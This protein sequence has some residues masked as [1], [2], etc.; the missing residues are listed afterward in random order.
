M[1]N[2]SLQ[3]N[4]TPLLGK[5]AL[6]IGASGGIGVS[7]AIML[8]QAG[9]TLELASRN[10]HKLEL[11]AEKLKSQDIASSTTECDISEPDSI[12]SLKENIEARGNV[13]ILV[14]CAGEADI[15]PLSFTDFDLWNR[16]FSIN[17]GGSF[18]STQAFIS[19]M[20]KGGWGRI[21][22]LGSQAGMSGAP[23]LSAYAASKQAVVGFV[24]SV[25]C[26]VEGKG[27][28]INA[29]CPGPVD[30]PMMQ[31]LIAK[32]ARQTASSEDSI[33]EIYMSGFER[34][35][36]P[37]EVADV[38]VRLCLPSMETSGQIVEINPK[39]RTW[40]QP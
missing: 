13:D 2:N 7:T 25:A 32:I 33:R 19:G 31:G 14:N 6:V 30:T 40:E 21:I 9:A 20:L 3:F 15:Q 23:Y 27:V 22:L 18:L 37:E 34:F 29:V 17:A 8:G 5:R 12:L 35:L 16:M 28:A 4:Q 39:I 36:F 10:L 11:V 1:L 26:E 38:I 24:R